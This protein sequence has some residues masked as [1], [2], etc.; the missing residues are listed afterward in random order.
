MLGYSPSLRLGFW[1]QSIFAIKTGATLK[2]VVYIFPNPSL[3]MLSFHFFAVF[4]FYSVL[5]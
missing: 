2:P 4:M 1:T 3:Q 5:L